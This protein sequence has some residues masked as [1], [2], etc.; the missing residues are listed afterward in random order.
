MII[1]LR[2]DGAL[3][4]RIEADSE[5]PPALPTD[6]KQLELMLCAR[7]AERFPNAQVQVSEDGAISFEDARGG[8][9]NIMLDNAWARVQAGEEHV[10]EQF[11]RLCDPINTENA[12]HE[13]FPLIKAAG[14]AEQFF[15]EARRVASRDGGT[16]EPLI[17]T[18]FAPD[19]ECLFVRD[20]PN[21]MNFITASQLRAASLD[22]PALPAH[23][24]AKLWQSLV[25]VLRVEVGS[26]VHML[27]CGGNY[28]TALLLLPEIWSEVDPL[29]TGQRVVAIPNRD[30]LFVTG[31]EN[32]SG[33][34]WMR[35]QAAGSAGR[36][37]P[38]TSHLFRWNGSR[39]ELLEA[40]KRSWLK[41]LFS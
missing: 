27:T 23:A 7:I 10:I 37:Y 19:L 32:A 3:A 26:G 17:H 2:D 28:E 14:T 8:R 41:R 29:L 21:G 33:I 36:S 35:E 1:A 39:Y 11:V 18:A 13:I 34:A 16:P 22:E 31:S 40:P 24:G 20:L 12:T 4:A 15:A 6:R 9:Q 38:I 30:L 25:T 5:P